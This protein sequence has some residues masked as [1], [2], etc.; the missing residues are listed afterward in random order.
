V[1]NIPIPRKGIDDIYKS[2]S[3]TNEEKEYIESH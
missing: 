1:L 3:L 2:Y